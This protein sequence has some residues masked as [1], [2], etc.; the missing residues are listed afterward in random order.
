M[1]GWNPTQPRVD[2]IHR[3][4]RESDPSD[5]QAS[6]GEQVP[7]Q[8]MRGKHGV[9]KREGNLRQGK[10]EKSRCDIRKTRYVRCRQMDSEIL[11][12]LTRVE[13]KGGVSESESDHG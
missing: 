2:Q 4:I 9:S 5:A 13:A 1:A 12:H 7:A 6:R 3:G 8:L 11:D 10:Q